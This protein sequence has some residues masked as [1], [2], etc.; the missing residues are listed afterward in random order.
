[1]PTAIRSWRGG[2]EARRR[3]GEGGEGAESYLKS[4]NPHLAGGEPSPK[5]QFVWVV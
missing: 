3:G 4:N 5:S 2:E 1:M